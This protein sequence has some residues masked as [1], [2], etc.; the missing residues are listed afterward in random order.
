MLTVSISK[1]FFG[2]SPMKMF[3]A[4]DRSGNSPGCWCMTATPAC[5]ASC[6]ESKRTGRP[7]TTTEPVD[8]RKTP[9]RSLTQVL[10][11]AP[12]SPRRARTSPRRSPKLAEFRATI[13]PKDLVASAKPSAQVAWSALLPTATLG[14]VSPCCSTEFPPDSTLAEMVSLRCRFN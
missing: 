4:M 10:L 9:A 8:G 2:I 1:W 14:L 6:G 12:F 5:C 7:S 13:G 3:W 11:P